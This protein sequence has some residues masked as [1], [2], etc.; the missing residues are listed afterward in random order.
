MPEV[1]AHMF[2]NVQDYYQTVADVVKKVP[3]ETVNQ[4]IALM[5][6]A[7]AE[8]RRI[9]LFGNGGS[10]AAA[11]HITVDL[12]K[13]TVQPD[14]PRLKV[15]CLNDNLPTITAYAND[16]SYAVI[17][18]EPLA[19]LAEPGDLAIAISGSGNSPN[20]LK[21]MDVAQERGLTRVGLT[22][23]QGGKL[24][25]KCNICVVVPSD[26]MQ[27]IEDVHLIILHSVFLQLAK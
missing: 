5:N 17:F 26:S 12:I 11:S 10:A 3:A 4:I 1:I 23:F 2:A 14:R 25:N 20:V 15:I 9:F 16:V 21:A 22:G 27:I 19:S 13:S 8:N 18:S 24:K 6:Q 7:R